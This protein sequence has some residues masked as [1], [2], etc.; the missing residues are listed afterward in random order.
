MVP[1]LPPATQAEESLTQDLLSVGTSVKTVTA[2]LTTVQAD[3]ATG[4]SYVPSQVTA[5]MAPVANALT[6]AIQ[7]LTATIPTLPGNTV[8]SARLLSDTLST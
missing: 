4:T 8:A 7:Q 3:A 2:S 5:E 6:T 1:A